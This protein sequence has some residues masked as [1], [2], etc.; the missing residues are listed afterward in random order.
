MWDGTSASPQR[1]ISVRKNTHAPVANSF[2]FLPSLSWQIIVCLSFP[3]ENS[4]NAMCYAGKWEAWFAAKGHPY[5]LGDS[6]SAP[7]FPLCASCSSCF[8]LDR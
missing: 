7:D 6:P 3:P 1:C 2:V 4:I 5:L 8:N